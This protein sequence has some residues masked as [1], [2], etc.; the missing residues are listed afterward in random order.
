MDTIQFSPHDALLIVDMQNDF[1]KNGALAVPFAEEIIPLVNHWINQ[2]KQQRIPIFA[3][4]DWHP[5]DHCSFES[6]GGPW[7]EHCIQDSHGSQFHPNLALPNTAIHINKAQSAKHETYS[8]L[9]GFDENG[10]L[11]LKTLG[12]MNIKRLWVC[13][14]ALD[15]CVRESAIEALKN[16]FEVNV[17]LSG[18]RA[19]SLDGMKS[20][21]KQLKLLKA[22]IINSRSDLQ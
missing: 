19:I 7:P 1:F 10:V 22:K 17:L 6:Q 13:G 20:T 16:N 2:A 4:R 8:A 14:L 15:F 5:A 11:L 12:K 21:L 9:S 3:S 18:T